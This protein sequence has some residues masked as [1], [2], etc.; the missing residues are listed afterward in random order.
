MPAPPVVLPYAATTGTPFSADGFNHDLQRLFDTSNGWLDGTSLDAG[1]RVLKQHVRPNAVAK[2]DSTGMRGT[3]HYYDDIFDKVENFSASYVL[4]GCSYTWHQRFAAGVA[5]INFG[6]F[7][8]VW[9]MSDKAGSYTKYD[10]ATKLFVDGVAVDHT[11]R[12]MPATLFDSFTGDNWL[13]Q[14]HYST[15]MRSQAHLVEGLTVGTHTVD[16]RVFLE[17]TE[18]KHIANRYGVGDEPPALRYLIPHRLTVGVRNLTVLRL[19]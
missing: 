16:V 9:K 6:A 15:R 3:L 11:R 14:E 19:K 17:R 18:L 13:V 10:V 7:A 8:S 12:S 4:P 2:T 1:F 5:Q